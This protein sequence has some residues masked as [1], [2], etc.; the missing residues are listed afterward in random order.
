MLKKANSRPRLF[1]TRIKLFFEVGQAGTN[2]DEV[3]VLGIGERV[4][5]AIKLAEEIKGMVTMGLSYVIII[6]LSGMGNGNEV[7]KRSIHGTRAMEAFVKVQAEFRG[8]FSVVE[9]GGDEESVCTVTFS[10][11]ECLLDML[12]VRAKQ[13]VQLALKRRALN[14]GMNL[15]VGIG[16]HGDLVFTRDI[17]SG[18]AFCETLLQTETGQ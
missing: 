16:L 18:S 1:K 11:E 8:G 13:K 2:V 5:L 4:V 3:V 12:S 14:H 7:E 17:G 6:K 15:V 9:V 10:V